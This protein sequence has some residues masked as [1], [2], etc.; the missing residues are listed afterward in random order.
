MAAELETGTLLNER[1]RIRGVIGRGGM[2]TVYLADH[3][4]LDTV[5]AVKEVRGPKEND[6]DFQMA[7]AQCEQEARFL[8]RLHHPNLP[9][10]TDAFVE[11][12]RFYLVMEY[13]EGETLE[14]R[15][16]ENGNR[17]L[18]VAQIVDWGLQVADVLAYLHSQEPPIIFRDM[19]PANIMVQ[20]DGLARLIDFGIA[21]RFQPGADKD[22]AL[23][24]SVGYSPPEQFGKHQTDTRS[25]IY[26]LGATLH[27]L[28]T[29]RDPASQPFKFPPAHSLN[30]AVPEPLSRLLEQCLAI[31]VEE[32]PAGIHEVALGLLAVRDEM[33]A[34]RSEASG[35]LSDS[36]PPD[37]ESVYTGPKIISAKL[38]EVEAKQ[39]RSQTTRRV[40]PSGAV[41]P[42]GG[43]PTARAGQSAWKTGAAAL[44]LLLA[45]GG[46][47]T[48]ALLHARPKAAA[49]PA[50]PAVT[51]SPP[52]VTPQPGPPPDAPAF[53]DPQGNRPDAG[54]SPAAPN[55]P[56]VFEK[57]DVQGL[58]QDAQGQYFLHL[59]ASGMVQ[60]Q[61]GRA[62]S[63]AAFF[64]DG[65][66]KPLPARDPRAVFA[67][68]DGQLSV[69]HS[70]QVNTDSQ[71]FA[72]VMDV[73][74]SQFPPSAASTEVRV[75]FVVFLDRQRVAATDL[76][77]VPVALLMGIVLNP[78]SSGTSV[79]AAPSS[80]D[81]SG[82]P[83][84]TNAPNGSNGATR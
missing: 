7:L 62:G 35:P 13:I 4:R 54:T 1:Y 29:G 39:R 84:G 58:A 23:L 80:G 5:V 45:G 9:T 47:V 83:G 33:A 79:P 63:V 68:P 11:K 77:P 53:S 82:S 72:V 73:P 46:A 6:S 28:L 48:V 44:L 49:H 74:L 70:L 42:S 12:D 21:R 41:S 67:N 69:A 38:A 40:P 43:V 71:P 64:Y 18:D 22:T 19:K 66:G 30:P 78:D 60:G 17:P 59:V 61:S 26:S 56:V 32:R 16:R 15:L 57:A 25:D 36:A 37:P 51:N 14:A 3:V 55:S 10:V 34:Q 8:V 31:D 50:K 27:Q 81:F 24:G 2:G 52:A 75:R 65:E 20:P 76:M